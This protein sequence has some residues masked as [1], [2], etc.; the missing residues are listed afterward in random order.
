MDKDSLVIAGR[1]VMLAILALLLAARASSGPKPDRKSDRNAA[2]P[3]EYLSRLYTA[4]GYAGG[5][6]RTA[7]DQRVCHLW[8]FQQSLQA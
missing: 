2:A 4:A 1:G 7:P 6:A 3:A 8:L 5:I